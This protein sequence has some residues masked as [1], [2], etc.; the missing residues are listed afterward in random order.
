LFKFLI[1]KHWYG[2]IFDIIS[3]KE[4]KETD[5]FIQRN[6]INKI[7]F[8]DYLETHKE[9]ISQI[10]V[11]NLTWFT[12]AIWMIEVYLSDYDL[13]WLEKESTKNLPFVKDII[14]K[15]Q[16]WNNKDRIDDIT[17]DL[18][19]TIWWKEIYEHI[20]SLQWW[21]NIKFWIQNIAITKDNFSNNYQI[22]RGL[23]IYIEKNKNR[24]IPKNS[25]ERNSLLLEYSQKV[26]EFVNQKDPQNAIFA[27]AKPWD[28]K[29]DKEFAFS[30]SLIIKKLLASKYK[31]HFED[32]SSNGG[33]DKKANTADD[34]KKII[35]DAQDSFVFIWYHWSQDS[36]AFK[37]WQL[38]D[39]EDLPN[40]SEID[41]IL[42]SCFGWNTLSYNNS[43]YSFSSS[44]NEES[45]T[46]AYS[47]NLIKWFLGE[48]WRIMWEEWNYIELRDWKYYMYNA[49]WKRTKSYI[50]LDDI[51][52]PFDSI[53]LM[54]NWDWTREQ[55]YIWKGLWN[56]KNRKISFWTWLYSG[57]NPPTNN[58]AKLY[59]MTH[60]K[61]SPTPIRYK[62][63]DWKM[64]WLADNWV[65]MKNEQADNV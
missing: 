27:A 13:P 38:Y 35:A 40:N 20:N 60:Y 52:E 61:T 57:Q 23:L 36:F 22:I 1:F 21:I 26:T 48:W 51:D 45:S 32:Y 33:N 7:D 18:L 16:L 58:D 47:Q 55:N 25:N 37:K 56:I 53:E 19:K 10:K 17:K 14:K 24:N 4:I 11:D 28:E 64:I 46:T 31:D 43:N 62:D 63:K 59:A 3:W 8:L 44:G 65:T 5:E 42:Y 49:D 30:E 41:I 39:K 15:I 29:E 50:F 2:N 9:E 12:F 6:Y 54:S 34:F